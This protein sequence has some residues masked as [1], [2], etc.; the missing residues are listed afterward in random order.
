MCCTIKPIML[1]IGQREFAWL[2]ISGSAPPLQPKQSSA[3]LVEG[4][5]VE[6]VAGGF[7]NIS[8]GAVLRSGN[9]Y[10]L[11]TLNG[12]RSTAGPLRRANFRRFRDNPLDPVQLFFDKAGD[13][14]VFRTPERAWCTA[15]SL[16]CKMMTL[17]C[18]RPFRRSRA[19]E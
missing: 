8:G 18:Y 6:K 1:E 17:C 10:F 9:L 12:K 5:K 11:W 13:L 7:F 3:V 16:A 4:S 15:L 2:T 19:R 14:I